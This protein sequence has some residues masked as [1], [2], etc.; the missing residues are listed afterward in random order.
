MVL[1]RYVVNL[2]RYHDGIALQVT[3]RNTEIARF[4]E[5]GVVKSE[6]EA[7]TEM[8]KAG[9]QFAEIEEQHSETPGRWRS[10]WE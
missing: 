1:R 9:F 3:W 6:L 4:P 10:R 2:I 8:F 5:K 7:I